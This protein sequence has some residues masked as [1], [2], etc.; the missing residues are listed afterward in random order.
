MTYNLKF[1]LGTKPQEIKNNLTG[2][3]FSEVGHQ[4][5]IYFG[6]KNNNWY[7][8]ALV[9]EELIMVKFENIEV[10]KWPMNNLKRE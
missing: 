5:N 7:C 8:G 2:M 6:Y 3:G 4:E 10:N 9:G 1:K